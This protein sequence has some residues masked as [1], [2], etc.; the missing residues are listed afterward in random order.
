MSYSSTKKIL[1]DNV[2]NWRV[3]IHIG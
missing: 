1:V 3:L 2:A